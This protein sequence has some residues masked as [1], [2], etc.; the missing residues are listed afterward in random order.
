MYASPHLSGTT[1]PFIVFEGL[2]VGGLCYL[3]DEIPCL[4]IPE[5]KE[6]LTIETRL[7]LVS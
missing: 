6:D 1:L 4:P 7:D 2:F 5:N 3:L